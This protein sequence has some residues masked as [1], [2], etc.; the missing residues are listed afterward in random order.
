M[1][2]WAGGGANCVAKASAGCAFGLVGTGSEGRAER[3]QVRDRA[4][5]VSIV[6]FVCWV[7]GA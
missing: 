1:A 6:R 2:S 7:L 3:H 4:M 5:V